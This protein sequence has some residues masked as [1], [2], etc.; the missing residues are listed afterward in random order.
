M[1]KFQIKIPAI[2][3][4]LFIA[5]L[6]VT[7]RTPVVD[8]AINAIKQLK[9]DLSAG[10]VPIAASSTVLADGKVLIGNSSGVAAA[11]TVSGDVTVSNA[12]VAA[13][14]TGVIVNADVSATAALAFSKFENLSSGRLL[15]GNGSNVPTE[16]DITGDVTISNAGV[17]T[18]GAGAVDTAM[19]ES[20]L[21]PSH[22]PKFVGELT[23]SGGGASVSTALVGALTTDIMVASIS[24]VPSEAAYLVSADVFANNST[25][26]VLSAANTSN[27]AVISYAVYRAA[28]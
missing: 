28:P 1:K 10:N 23:W 24:T 19:L 11:Q 20:G 14:G 8:A 9:I 22:V 16:T 7:Y 17:T 27:D 26:F 4:I 13:I 3:V 5:V 2:V 12:G 21:Q 25:S 18:I 15:V 6:A